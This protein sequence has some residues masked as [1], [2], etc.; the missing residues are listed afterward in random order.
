MK[1][2]GGTIK[3][4]TAQLND[5]GIDLSGAS[6]TFSDG[7]IENNTAIESAG[8]IGIY[9]STM[10]MSG[11]TVRNNTAKFSA[12]I[13]DFG[14]SPTA[15]T[16]TMTG[17]TVSGNTSAE[18]AAGVRVG[19]NSTFTLENGVI[20]NNTTLGNGGGISVA[21]GRPIV[22]TAGDEKNEH[23]QLVASPS[24]VIDLLHCGNI[25]VGKTKVR[26]SCLLPSNNQPRQRQ[27][28]KPS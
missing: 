7:V 12:G 18:G 6:M 16:F 2:T 4:N 24:V 27:G 17:G 11:G 25:R 23:K 1:M 15:S 5:G 8:G 20:E 28:A 22:W 21:E 9:Q 10:V 19:T 26:C 14:S 13:A 3:G